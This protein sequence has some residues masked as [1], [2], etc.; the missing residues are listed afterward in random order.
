MV[1][2]EHIKNNIISLPGQNNT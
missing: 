2:V 1:V